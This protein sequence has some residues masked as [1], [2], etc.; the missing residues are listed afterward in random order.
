MGTW[1]IL[2]TMKSKSAKSETYPSAGRYRIVG[3]PV[4]LIAY[5]APWPKVPGICQ[6]NQTRN[7]LLPGPL[8]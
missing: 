3:L 4:P 5:P 1:H 2:I 8:P 6:E 7:Q